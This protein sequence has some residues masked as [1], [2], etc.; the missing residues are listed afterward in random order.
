MIALWIMIGIWLGA[1]LGTW[2]FSVVMEGAVDKVDLLLL[3]VCMAMGPIGTLLC[4]RYY[5]ER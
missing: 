2:V 5:A 3:V 4:A 1:G